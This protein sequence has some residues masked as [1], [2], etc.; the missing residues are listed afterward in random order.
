MA[1][2]ICLWFGIVLARQLQCKTF[3]C[4]LAY[5]PCAVWLRVSCLLCPAPR[6]ISGT[7]AWLPLCYFAIK[8]VW[9]RLSRPFKQR[10]LRTSCGNLAR[11]LATAN[12]HTL[13]GTISMLRHTS[14]PKRGYRSVTGFRLGFWAS[15]LLLFELFSQ[16]FRFIS[17]NHLFP[18]SLMVHMYFNN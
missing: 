12:F 3:Y 5:S 11:Q 16:F 8:L 14:Y 15:I 18:L 6:L 13:L 2:Y 1:S 10:R 17:L 7:V 4:R 9:L